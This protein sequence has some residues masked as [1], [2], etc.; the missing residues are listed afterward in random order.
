ME[1]RAIGVISGKGGVGKTSL[2]AS[3]ASLASRDPDITPIIMDCDVDAPNLALILPAENEHNIDM[4]DT[5]TTLKA[6]FIEDKCV[7]CKQCIEDKFCEFHALSWDEE[8]EIPVINYLACEGCGA[9]KVLCPEHAFEIHPVK[10]GE[11][12]SYITK[13]EPRLVY[14][15]TELGS[16]TSGKLVSE[17]KEYAQDL[18]EYD[19]S[20]FILI[21]GPPGIGCPVIATVT[22]LDYIITIC[23][24]TPSGVH[25]V[26]RAIEVVQQFEIPF[27]IVINKADLKS[28]FQKEFQEFIDSTG[29]DV[30]GRIPFDLQIAHAM[31][32]AE[33]V[34]DYAPDSEASKAI[35][36]IFKKLKKRLWDSSL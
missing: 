19:T 20:N 21:D 3:L 24:P 33:P 31:A 1:R 13:K 30:L 36:E 29:Y 35:I 2:T 9:C 11:I 17:S 23:E 8:Q 5:Y 28:P 32:N 10:S 4:Q 7:H 26:K 6:T 34:V 14:G 15:R 16:T 18:D 25:D 27:G 22:G 12:I